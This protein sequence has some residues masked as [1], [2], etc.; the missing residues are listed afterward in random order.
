MEILYYAKR[1]IDIIGPIAL[2]LC[3]HAIWEKYRNR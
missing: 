3:I 1:A 2:G